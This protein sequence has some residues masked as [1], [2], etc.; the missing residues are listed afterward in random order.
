[1]AIT[2]CQIVLISV[3]LLT[4]SVALLMVLVKDG[5][6]KR[7]AVL[8]AVYQQMRDMLVQEERQAQIEVDCELEVGQTKLREL[9][10][11]FTDN[12]ETMR[13]ARED[14]NSLLSQSQT[15]GFLQVG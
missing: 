4:L 13:K 1:M 15:I 11:R 12:A 6:S 8:A 5:A 7:K 2:K 9:M 3:Y 14:I 10:K